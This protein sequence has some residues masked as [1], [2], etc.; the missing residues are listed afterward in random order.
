M[1]SVQIRWLLAAWLLGLLADGHAQPLRGIVR[2]QSTRQIIESAYVTLGRAPDS[3]VVAFT[4]TNATGLFELVYALET[5]KQYYLNVSHI[6]YRTALQ[7]VSLPVSNLVEIGMEPGGLLLNEVQVTARIPVR[8][9]GDSTRYKVDAFRNGSERTLE[10]VLKKMPNVRVEQN[11]DIYFKERRVEKV[12]LDG[13]DLIGETYQL[14][15]RSINPA[16][17]NEVQAIENFSENKLLRKIEQSETT[18][19]NLT[20][21]N[22]QKALLFGTVD[23]GVGPQRYNG[24]TNLFSYSK[25]AK[26]FAVLSANNVGTRHLDL[27]DAAANVLTDARPASELLVKPFTQTSQP[28]IRNLNSPL[29]NVNNERVGTFNVAINPVKALKITANLSLLRDQVQ[30]GRSQRYE[31]IGSD[32]LLRYQQ[33]DSLRQRPTLALLRLRA[34]YSLTD[35]TALVYKGTTGTKTINLSQATQFTTG[36][37]VSRFPQQFTNQIYDSQH[38]L[39]LTHKLTTTQALVLSAQATDTR[40]TERYDTRLD[41]ALATATFGTRWLPGGAFE[42]LVSQRNQLYGGQLQWMYGT[43]LRKFEQQVGYTDNQFEAAVHQREGGFPI[44]NTPLSLSRQT[45][46]SR[47]TGRLLWP[48]LEIAGIFQLSHVSATINQQFSRRT[49][50]QANLTVSYRT[51]NLSRLTLAY[52]RQATPV[53]NTYLLDQAAVTDFRSAQRGYRGLLFDERNQLSATY[54]FTDMAFRHMTFLL[55]AFATRSNSFWNMGDLRFSPDYSVTTLINTPGVYTLGVTSTLEK[56]V[57]PISGNIRL[58]VNLMQNQAQQMVNGQ[59]RNTSHFMPIVTAKY[60][61]VFESPFNVEFSGTYRHTLVSGTQEDQSFRQA[62]T[63]MNGYSQL[64]YRQKKY[65]ISLKAE[66]NRIRQDNYTFLNANATYQL[67]PKLT[68]RAEA[69]NLLNQTTYKQVS[70]TPTTYS[71]GI[72]PL[73]PRMT[74]LYARYSF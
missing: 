20:V 3:V 28:F 52:E 21:N 68:L 35:R 56:L 27:S 7:P 60:V 55:S 54:L 33:T 41:S 57:Y 71:M 4:R 47:T 40:L 19:L 11:G 14:A 48:R 58:N 16:L 10:E 36:D 17:L 42:Q 66:V 53:S 51:S 1:K 50:I 74:L 70:I 61:S 72:Y 38:L 29:E 24:I 5:G 6:S 34:D 49:P 32:T 43:K 25:Y 69:L 15:T 39:E 63:A 8:E 13:D 67:T 26:A 30:A 64:F 18:V 31:L 65:Q 12:L 45:I 44:N 59:P 9:Q 2:N 62:F 37:D 46:Y 23:V 73:L 22:S